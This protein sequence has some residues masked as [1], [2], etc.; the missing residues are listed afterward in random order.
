MQA[1]DILKSQFVSVDFV[2]EYSSFQENSAEIIAKLQEAEKNG[3]KEILI[4]DK[5][6]PLNKP[7]EQYGLVVD[8]ANLST[9]N[10]TFAY[11]PIKFYA[12][13]DVYQIPVD[14]SHLPQVKTV[15]LENHEI[16]EDEKQQLID[17]R[18]DNYSFNL[19]QVSLLARYHGIKTIGVLHLCK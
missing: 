17:Y 6:Y 18:I 2:S 9:H 12:V 3:I 13:N 16:S 15:C 7:A 5:G 11:K 10:P 8:H 4:L 19:V 1:L 14:L